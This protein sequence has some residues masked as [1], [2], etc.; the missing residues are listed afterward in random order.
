MVKRNAI[1]KIGGKWLI[2]ALANKNPPPQIIGTQIAM[3]MCKGFIGRY[4]LLL[5]GVSGLHDQTAGDHIPLTNSKIYRPVRKH[6]SFDQAYYRRYYEDADSKV[7]SDTETARRGAYV[8]AYLEYLGQPVHEVLDLGCG[9]GRWR[10]IVKQFF[11]RASYQGVDASGY[12]CQRYGWE[13]ISIERF[14]SAKRYDL[15]ICQDVLQYLPAQS[16]AKVIKNFHRLCRGVLY[17]Q[18]MTKIDWDENCD[19]EYSDGDV[20]LRSGDWYRQRL[21]KNF[22]NVGGGCFVSRQSDIVLYELESVG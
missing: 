20:Y 7:E 15:V 14:K 3:K 18:A 4:A 12:L 1:N 22:I 13:C 19:Q 9:V 16:A 6:F 10:S 8:C 21:S 17:L 2:A 5:S 11:P